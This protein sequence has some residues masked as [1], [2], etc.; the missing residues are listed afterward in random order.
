[1]TIAYGGIVTDTAGEVITV[2]ATGVTSITPIGLLINYAVT[3]DSVST[4]AGP[5]GLQGTNVLLINSG[6]T[7]LN[8]VIAS[9][10]VNITATTGAI[11]TNSGL[12]QS[13]G[14]TTLTAN[15]A[16]G[17]IGV[18]SVLTQNTA[19]ATLR[20]NTV[21]DAFINDS[22]NPLSLG[23][24]N[25]TGNLVMQ[26]FATTGTLTDS[27]VLTV[28][29]T[30]TIDAGLL[31]IV[32]DQPTSSFGAV[33]ALLADLVIVSA[34]NVYVKDNGPLQLGNIG[35][36][37]GASPLTGSLTLF[38]GSGSDITQMFKTRSGPRRSTTH[39]SRAGRR[40]A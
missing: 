31:D 14:V 24:S 3:L 6:A 17:G 8:N 20:L 12:I 5:I 16:G 4:Y 35:T 7:V 36:G 22:G 37:V 30:L 29:G 13:T 27:G 15:G 40:P 10:T 28:G 11:T 19:V 33:S 34:N 2:A 1:M 32:L 21:G 26:V 23:T 9:G 25:V 39:P 38:S 18:S